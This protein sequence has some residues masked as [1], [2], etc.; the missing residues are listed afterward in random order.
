MFDDPAARVGF[1]HPVRRERPLAMRRMA[2]AQLIMTA[3]LVLSIV[4]AGTAVSIGIAR[5]ACGKASTACHLSEP[6]RTSYR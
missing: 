1:Q 6:Q 2:F 3:A 5:A 4:V